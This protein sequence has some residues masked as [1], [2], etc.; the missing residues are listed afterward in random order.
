MRRA[1]TA[2]AATAGTWLSWA[3]TCVGAALTAPRAVASRLVD[4]VTGDAADWLAAWN[5]TWGR[6][7]T[8]ALAVAPAADIWAVNDIFTIPAGLRAQRRDGGMI[9][10]NVRD[11]VIDSG[12]YLPQPSWVRAWLGR[13]ERRAVTRS[14]AVVTTT[15]AMA[16]WL[17]ARYQPRVPIVITHNCPPRP[18]I[19][20]P[21]RT[22]LLR[23]AAGVGPM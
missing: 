2:K 15:E 21:K 14:A 6:W 1:L 22:G 7:A 10:Y 13:L 11:L 16:D 18:G 3:G 12:P 17:R 19:D 8:E 20:L 23:A 4:L 9:I 5:A